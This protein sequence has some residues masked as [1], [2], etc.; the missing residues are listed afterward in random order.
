MIYGSQ[1]RKRGGKKH[2]TSKKNLLQYVRK[3]ISPGNEIVKEG[4]LS[5]EKC[6]GYFSEKDGEI[7]ELDLCEECYNK[8]IKQ[9]KIPVTVK[10]QKEFV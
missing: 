5:V 9:F 4:I 1:R 6:W 3:R 7:H 8:L 10:K 2:E